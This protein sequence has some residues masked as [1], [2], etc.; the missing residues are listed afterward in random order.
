M[1]AKNGNDGND[2]ICSQ[3]TALNRII[4]GH[5]LACDKD[6]DPLVQGIK[7]WFCCEYFHAVSCIDDNL[8]VAASTVFNNHLKAA[9]SNTGVYERRFGRFLFSCDYCLTLEE[10]KRCA[11]SVDRIDLLDKKIHEMNN[12][13]I[14]EL[15]SLK[16]LI[17]KPNQSDTSEISPA[18]ASSPWNDNQRTDNLRHTMSISKDSNGNSVNM[19]SM[20]KICI[21]N[22]IS[23]HKTFNMQKSESTGIVLN[24]KSDADL[25]KQK[26]T[27]NLPLH[28]IEEVAA[29]MP[30]I[31]VVGL[32]R[33]YS[34]EELISMIKRQNTGICSLFEL[35]E[36]NPQDQVMNILAIKPLRNKP[37]VFK[38]IIRVSNV[39]RS[40]I[41]KQGDRLF[42][43]FQS[44]CK[45]YDNIFV[46]RCFKCQEYNHHS[47][48]CKNAA[49][50]GFCSGNH[51]TRSCSEKSNNHKACCI[52]CKKSGK[53]ISD[54]SHE[55][56]SVECPIYQQN[57][58]KVKK[59]IPFYQGK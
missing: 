26:L 41:S 53:A 51:E 3:N 30:T 4:D 1:M 10:E 19:E 43:G 32:Q 31:A 23:V 17:T 21:E 16:E 22:G 15:S 7:C 36:N 38:A 50:C 46:L 18:S 13:F 58:E 40:I 27:N 24:S 34:K 20:E 25:L 48:E 33:E 59:S 8:C 9:V 14:S 39:I 55:A 56:G 57:Q 44:S 49:V 37:D 2:G 6:I 42:V 12:T 45:V 47:R 52:N 28:K 29:K 35:S 54:T 5:C 11:S